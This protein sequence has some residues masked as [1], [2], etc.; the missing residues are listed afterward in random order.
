MEVPKNNG[1][2]HFME[3]LLVQGVPS[4]PNVEEF[5]GYI[6]SLAGSYGAHTE[7]LLVCFQVTLPAI[8]LEDAARIASEVFFEPLFSESAM[9]REKGAIAEELKQ[10]ADSHWYRIGQFYRQTRF[11]PKSPMVLDIGGKIEVINNLKRSDLVKFWQSHIFP[12][13]TYILVS[14]Q[15]SSNHLSQTLER[16]LGKYRSK[17]SFAGFPK[18]SEGD[19][20]KER[21]AIRF[22][23]DLKANYVDLTFPSLNLSN[24]LETRLKQ[25]LALIIL[26][27]I[28]NS[29]LFKL[30]R[31]QRGLVY[32]VDCG[33]NVLPGLGYVYI[34]SEVSTERLREV[35]S[36]IV[37]EI[38][39]FV[40]NGPTLKELDFVKNYLSNRWLMTFDH[41]TA[42]TGWIENDLL[43]NDKIRLPEEYIEI[44]QKFT[45][46]DLL[47]LMQKYWDFSKLSLTVQGPTKDD[48][49]TRTSLKSLLADLG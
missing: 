15:F 14:G 12:Q 10:H 31:Y 9:K 30:L 26:G 19:F 7:K 49:K 38:S 3:H 34:S 32:N 24:D 4:L 36:L 28:R 17:K 48:Q 33:A 41:P 42:I 8:H 1:I 18:L 23:K 27:G 25:N 11:V 22:D 20:S 43:W 47:K 46:L 37:S 45:P 35:V 44:I 21:V 5:S 6:E 29:R 13:N 39:A 16:F 2:A 40:K